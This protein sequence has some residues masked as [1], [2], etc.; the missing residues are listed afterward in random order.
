M[1][2]DANPAPPFKKGRITVD[3]TR[4]SQRAVEPFAEKNAQAKAFLEAH[5]IPKELL[6]GEE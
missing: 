3:R 5:P 6:K 4:S 2:T 1:K